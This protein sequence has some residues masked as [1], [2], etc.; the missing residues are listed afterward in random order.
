[1]FLL[2]GCGNIGIEYV[3]CLEDIKV[4]FDIVKKTPFKKDIKNNFRMVRDIYVKDLTS[5]RFEKKYQ[6]IILCTP[7][8]LLFDHLNYILENCK[9][10]ENILVEKPGCQFACQMEE[11]IK[12]SNT[13]IYIGYNRRFYS[14]VKK[15][16]DII[17]KDSPIELNLEINEPYP[18]KINNNYFI[19]QT[20]HVID[21]AFFICGF[22]RII[23]T[24]IKGEGIIQNHLRGSYFE[25]NG[26]TKKSIPFKYKGRW[27]E[28]KK[29]WKIEIKLKSGKVLILSPLEILKIKEGDKIIELEKDSID[30]NF[31]PGLY[32]QIKN[33]IDGN[34]SNFLSIETQKN[35][36]IKYYYPMSNYKS[37]FYVLVVGFGNI[38][39]RHVEALLNCNIKNI[40][41]FIVDKIIKNK[42]EKDNILYYEN[43]TNL[44]QKYFDMA[45]ISTCSFERKNILNF[46]LENKHI[47]KIILEKVVFQ[48]LKDFE[49]INHNKIFVN[50]PL[51]D[52][53]KKFTLDI[54]FEKPIINVTTDHTYGICCN[55]IHLMHFFDY[56]FPNINLELQNYKNIILGESKRK[57]Y[58]EI[59]EG[60]MYNHDVKFLI[61]K[62]YHNLFDIEIKEDNRKLY[63]MLTKNNGVIK[64]IYKK[65]DK[66]V[67]EKEEKLTL[68]SSFLKKEFNKL[69]NNQG[70]EFFHLNHSY[71]CHRFF[72]VLM[73]KIF[74]NDTIPI[75]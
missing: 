5:F 24:E 54:K 37:N 3:K 31:K 8:E 69:L 44:E 55:I 56:N 2:I 26:I 50:S 74:K 63:I 18:E 47:D 16:L 70:T 38:G 30:I 42:I 6:N 40:K 48:S 57:G 10:I 67:Y 46:L 60:E 66:I 65:D 34:F 58:M 43:L 71:K 36:C 52:Q 7:I 62:K 17:E 64:I 29:K 21:L 59:L 9:D 61:K 45:I 25:G 41:I 51:N 4:P 27:V 49:K 12:K 53:F 73:S 22:P 33:F 14:S 28:T 23:N 11:I 19:N 15:I 75:T 13:N 72:M 32:N 39:F 20:S 1:M 68:T 35:N